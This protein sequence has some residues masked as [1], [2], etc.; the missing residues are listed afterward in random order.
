M[1]FG[2][3]HLQCAQVIEKQD[4]IGEGRWPMLEHCGDRK[5][6][7]TGADERRPAQTAASNNGDV[8]MVED[9]VK[10]EWV[11]ALALRP[12]PGP[13]DPGICPGPTPYRARECRW[14]A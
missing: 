3:E 5:G 6:G 12:E 13:V 10:P 2:V 11:W 14:M 1:G 4:I 8:A 9:L 7:D